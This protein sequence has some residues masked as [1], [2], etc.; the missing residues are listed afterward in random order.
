MRPMN[1]PLALCALALSV[2]LLLPGAARAIE[3]G[4]G[5]AEIHGFYQMEFRGIANQFEFT[6]FNPH[7]WAHTIN[8]E[9]EFDLAPD[10]IGPFSLIQAFIRVE[11]RY[12]CV[13]NS[14]CHIATGQRLWGDEANRAPSQ[15]TNGKSSGRTGLF[16]NINSP[17]ED[18]HGSGARLVGLEEIPPL[19]GIFAL[20]GDS[21]AAALERTLAPINGL[22]FAVK[23]VQGSSA[24]SNIPLPWLPKDVKAN[25]ALRGVETNLPSGATIPIALPF[26][27]VPAD[28]S[29]FTPSWR[30]RE[31]IDD[32]DDLDINFSEEELVWNRGASQQQVKELREAYVDLE[33]LDGALWLRIGRQTTV[34]G[35]TELF[36][37]QDQFNPQDIALATLSSLESSRIP[38]WSVRGVMSFWDVGPFQDVRLEI[39]ANIDHFEPTD[40]GMCGEPYTVW[41]ICGKKAGAFSH[42]LLGTGIAGEE[43]PQ[44]PWNSLEGLEI[45]ARLEWRWNRFSFALTNFWGHTD[46][47]VIDTFNEYQ[48]AVDP[49][50]GR[51]LD[52]LG[53]VMNPDDPPSY[54]RIHT[55]N[56]QFFD[57]VCSVTSGLVSALG[58]QIAGLDTDS[59]CAL[60][61]FNHNDPFTPVIGTTIDG[62]A[63]I[64][65]YSLA[66]APYWD[67][68]GSLLA[69]PTFLD[70][71][72]DPNLDIPLNLDPRDGPELPVNFVGFDDTCGTRLT[73]EQE[74]LLGTGRFYHPD[75]TC[76]T[77]IC[78]TQGIDLFH[79][80]ASI[81]FQAFPQFDGPVATRFHKGKLRILPGARGPGDKGYD[82][83][84]DGCVGNLDDSI[85]LGKCETAADLI[86]PRTGELFRSEMEAASFNFMLLMA[87]LSTALPESEG[88]DPTGLAGTPE[89]PPAILN[90][91]LLKAIF[92]LAG[93]RRP[94]VSAGGNGRFGRRDF[95]YHAGSE[96]RLLYKK[97]NVLGFSMD[98]AEDWSKTNWGVEFVWFED[99]PYSDTHEKDGWSRHDTLSLTVSVDRPTF[100]NF[101]NANRTVFF[102]AQ[103]FVRWIDDY[104]DKA[105][106]PDGPFSLLMTFSAFTG[107]WQDRLLAAVTQVHELES[108][109]GGTIVNMTYRMTENFSMSVGLTTFYGDPRSSRQ[110]R[111]PLSVSSTAGNDYESR[112]RYNGLSPVADREELYMT[113]RYTF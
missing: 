80:E 6:N 96:V 22:K 84:I 15:F 78:F 82:P 16:R 77:D 53:R 44:D 57:V 36:R 4:E 102:N 88:C 50:T 32:F 108:N 1:R 5:F 81:L 41:L 33:L 99:E 42:G 75:P 14:M 65:A 35:K 67:L 46:T 27:P 72:F 31:L 64:F 103:F 51:P 29:L 69:G 71:P 94:E 105:L 83:D 39:A 2:V 21:A 111:V 12:D 98:F 18:V 87:V 8:V 23:H 92:G 113:L 30:L 66:G 63:A 107:F 19:D 70:I 49:V 68:I 73:D 25:G 59:L 38:L 97:R 90:C 76:T 40:L 9:A 43:R 95:L 58:D 112:L 17:A 3:F 109:S 20:G 10:G 86:D 110:A 13:W 28:G 11:G 61:A 104:P 37:A 85:D 93:A 62:L 48:R 45:G 91:G 26:R 56:R 79:A 47:P 60:D 106:A 101:F 34:W 89:D 7:Q 55:G 74:A 52:A 100:I 24:P 54:E